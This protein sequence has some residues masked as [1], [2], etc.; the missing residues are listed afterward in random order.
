[1]TLVLLQQ[2][3][4]GSTL[5]RNKTDFFEEEASCLACSHSYIVSEGD[6]TDVVRS[7]FESIQVPAKT[8]LQELALLQEHRAALAKALPSEEGVESGVSDTLCSVVLTN[9]LL[10]LALFAV[11]IWSTVRKHR[12]PKPERRIHSIVHPFE[13][14]EEELEDEEYGENFE[15]SFRVPNPTDQV[16]EVT[17]D[18]PQSERSSPQIP[19]YF[20]SSEYFLHNKD[21]NRRH[22]CPKVETNESRIDGEGTLPSLSNFSPRSV[23]RQHSDC[24]NEFA[25]E[26]CKG[27]AST[28]QPQ[29]PLPD[30]EPLKCQILTRGTRPIPNSAVLKQGWRPLK[31]GEGKRTHVSW[32]RLECSQSKTKTE[33]SVS[34]ARFL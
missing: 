1:M 6:C 30:F 20:A 21:T 2:G 11:L 19:V 3:V 15:P 23:A 16:S 22:I 24:E 25:T 17:V 10:L 14:Q 34:I 18:D 28:P 12:N 27:T 8:S 33:L 13:H 29:C 26:S 32:L 5:T 7:Q 31:P 9:I 4:I